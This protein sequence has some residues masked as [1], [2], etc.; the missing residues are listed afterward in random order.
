MTKEVHLTKGYV[1]TVDDEDYEL[2][3]RHTWR[4]QVRKSGNAYAI[5]HIRRPDGKQTT[6]SMHRLI[7]GVTDAKVQV[8]HINGDALDNR[9]VNM[10]T[11]TNAQNQ[12]NKGTTSGN[13]SGVKGVSWHK[14]DNRWQANIC[15]N[16][17]SIHLGYFDIKSD[18]VAAY[19]IAAIKHHGEFARFG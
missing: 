8:D 13:V 7:V 18:A 19:Q 5:T 2:V 4:V 17:K 14:R 10:R 1:A 12:R 16:L 3:K 6:L 11:C 15:V 9:R